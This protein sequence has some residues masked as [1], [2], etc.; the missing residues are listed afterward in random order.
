MRQ[1]IAAIACGIFVMGL[2]ISAPAHAEVRFNFGIGVGADPDFCDGPFDNRNCWDPPFMGP[3][4][5]RPPGFVPYYP[6]YP[7]RQPAAA[8][9][10]C[11]TGARIVLGSGYRSVRAIDCRGDTYRYQA[12]RKGKPVEIRMWSR[13]GR[14]YRVTPL[15]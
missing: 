15:R 10:S 3:P 6:Y 9:I 1:K 7:Y 12:S 2:A 14:I 8:R 11:D 5:I 4:G 13:T